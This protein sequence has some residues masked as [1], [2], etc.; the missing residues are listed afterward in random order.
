MAVVCCDRR[1]GW[2]KSNAWIAHGCQLTPDDVS[3]FAKW[4]VGVAHCPCS[5]SRLADGICPV[6]SCY[7]P[8]TLQ[9]A[10]FT[11]LSHSCVVPVTSVVHV[12]QCVTLFDAF[13]VSLLGFCPLRCLLSLFNSCQLVSRSCHTFIILYVH[14]HELLLDS[15]Q[16]SLPVWCSAPA[17][18]VMMLTVTAVALSLTNQ[19]FY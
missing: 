10:S 2:N 7:T 16:A 3:A 8:V 19:Q 11:L 1:M 9:S 4:Q 15:P 6:S 5:N 17:L 13:V 12:C 14:S 18:P